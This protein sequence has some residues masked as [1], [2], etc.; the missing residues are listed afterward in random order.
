MS[1]SFCLPHPVAVS[2]FM[3]CRGSTQFAQQLESAVT[4]PPSLHHSP[5][6]LI[7]PVPLSL[8]PPVPLFLIP[9]VPLSP[10]PPVPLSPCPSVPVVVYPLP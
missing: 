7:P 9:P 2:A 5:L 8:I 3:I 6:S 4:D 10:C 1:V